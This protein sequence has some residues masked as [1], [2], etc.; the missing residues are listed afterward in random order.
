MGVIVGSTLSRESHRPV[1]PTSSLLPSH[2]AFGRSLKLH[3]RT[4]GIRWALPQDPYEELRR[5]GV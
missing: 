5:W 3:I 4:V 2:K 1:S